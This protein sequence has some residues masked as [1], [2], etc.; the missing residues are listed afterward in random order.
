MSQ[1]LPPQTEKLQEKIKHIVVLML[2]NRSFDNLLG[3]LY[4]E[5]KPPNSQYFE[6]LNDDLWNPLDNID[7]NGMPFVEKVPIQK[8]G[9]KKS[10]YGKTESVPVDYCFPDPDPGEG[11]KDTNHQLFSEYNVGALYPP[12]PIN[13]GFVQN[14]QNAMLYGAYSFGDSPSNPRDIMKCFTP[15]QTPVLSSLA[16]NFAVCD[17]YHCSI[18]SQTLPNRSFVHAATSGGNV[19]NSP[20]SFTDSKTIYNQIQD[21]IDGGRNDLSWGVF[22]SNMMPTSYYKKQKDKPGETK[23][24]HF[25]LTRLCM[26]QLHDAKYDDNF[27]TLDDF[28][29]KC[30]DGTLPSYSF[31]E[32]CYGGEDQNDQHPPADI[33]PGEQLMADLYNAVKTSKS[34]ENTLFIITYDEHGGCYD[35]VPPPGEAKNPDPNNQ[36]GQEGFLFNRFGVRVPCILINPYITQGLIARPKGYVPFDHTSI[37]KTVQECFKLEGHLTARD[38]AAPSFS[39]VLTEASPRTSFPEVTPQKWDTRIDV[40]HEND[41]H[42]VMGKMVNK[43]TGDSNDSGDKHHLE[44]LQ[45]SYSKHFIH[46]NKEH[47]TK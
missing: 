38:E 30:A 34:F 23:D 25:S 14:Y 27:G 12:Q 10:K 29:Q 32:P 33:R 3:W 28:K 22:S 9:V 16:K 31:L 13:M 8:N 18:P 4:D 44:H 15:E 46:R 37:I 41:L 5:E 2:E 20:N 43:L 7:S 26:T 17:H 6:G 36:P 40:D 45:E 39:A 21:A 11:F 24:D 35:H 19:N 1:Y 47:L 42:R